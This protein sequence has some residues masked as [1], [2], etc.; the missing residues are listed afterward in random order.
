[1]GHVLERTKSIPKLEFNENL[2]LE[3]N[4]I[5]HRPKMLQ[6]LPTF[7]RPRHQNYVINKNKIWKVELPVGLLYGMDI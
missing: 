2:H 6:V 4:E 5:L 1:M 7:L 3:T